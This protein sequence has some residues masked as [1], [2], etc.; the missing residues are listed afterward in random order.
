[1]NEIKRTLQKEIELR[2]NPGKAVLLFGAR[3]VG[4]TMLAKHI[5]NNYKGKCIY[6]NG[7]DIDSQ[8][9]LMNRSIVNYRNIFSGYDLLVIDE[10]QQVPEIGKVIKLIVDEIDGISVF[11]TGSSS[12]DLLK[13]AGEPLVGRASQ[14]HLTPFSQQ[15]ITQIESPFETQQNLATRLIYGSYP[16]VVIM[17]NNEMREEYLRDLVYSYLL[18]DILMIDGLRNAAKM[19]RLLQLV[20][21]QVGSEVSYDELGRQLAMSRDTVEKYLDLLSKVFIIYKVG[22]FAR[23]LRKEISKAGKWYFLDNGIRNAI[24]GNFQHVDTRSDMG[25]LWENYLIAEAFKKNYNSLSYKNFYFWRTYD[26][27]EIDFIE[28][29]DG[30]IHSFEFKWGK[31]EPKAPKAFTTA[32]PD[33]TFQVVNPDNYL[34]FIVRQ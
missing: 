27:Q 20:A 31:K 24:I 5:M 33:A 6:L 25:E 16:E 11:A 23:N 10:A 7:E 3:R 2:L 9:V 1:M 29:K 32:Y 12:F 14:M 19:Q 18:K 21:Y 34:D 15:E 22:A 30:V 28:E 8:S 4:K 26:Q 13:K 17:D